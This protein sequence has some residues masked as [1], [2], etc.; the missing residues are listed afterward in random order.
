MALYTRTLLARETSRVPLP[1]LLS[2]FLPST[3]AFPF[4]A[5]LFLPP[6]THP[7]STLP[8]HLAFTACTLSFPMHPLRSSRHFPISLTG[9][10]A[11]LCFFLDTSERLNATTNSPWFSSTFL[12][13]FSSLFFFLLFLLRFFAYP[14]RGLIRH[15]AAATLPRGRA[16]R[17]GFRQRVLFSASVSRIRASRE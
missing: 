7:P 12:P 11:S 14:P 6:V 9:A 10:T 1:R 16:G 5:A 13:P 8:L 15:N 2:L 3:F 4:R 17:V